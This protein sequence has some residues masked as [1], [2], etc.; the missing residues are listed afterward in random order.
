MADQDRRHPDL[1]PCRFRALDASDAIVLDSKGADVLVVDPPRKGLCGPVLEALTTASSGTPTTSL[2]RLIYISCGFDA[3]Q[4]DLN[5]LL[6][7]KR[8]ALVDAEAHVLFPGSD[9]VETLAVFD[10]VR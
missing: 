5:A 3:F 6:K 2:S 8:W 1:A 9:H 7:S 10:A 4:H